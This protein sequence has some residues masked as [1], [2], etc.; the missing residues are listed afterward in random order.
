MASIEFLGVRIHPVSDPESQLVLN[1]TEAMKVDVS[2][3]DDDFGEVQTMCNG[4]SRAVMQE[5][6][7]RSVSVSVTHATRAT[8]EALE[9]LRG[10]LVLYRDY[11]GNCL[12]GMILSRRPSPKPGVDW[13]DLSFSVV[14]VTYDPAV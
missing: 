6:R 3:A 8:K 2:E 5:G 13:Y 1:S 12:Y 7:N 11:C 4:R 10:Q 14:G 9:S